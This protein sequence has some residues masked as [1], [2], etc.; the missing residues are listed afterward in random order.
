MSLL[1]WAWFAGG[2]VVLIVGAE[3]FV[4]GASRLA[5]AAGISPLVIGLTVVAYSGFLFVASNRSGV[6]PVA[7]TVAVALVTPLLLATV[8]VLAGL[9]LNGRRSPPCT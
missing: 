5:K 8:L 4:R 2:L 9:L 7:G 1:A 3:L 6:V